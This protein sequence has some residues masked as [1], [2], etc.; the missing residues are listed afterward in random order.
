ML[1]SSI[2]LKLNNILIVPH[3]VKNLISISQPI[4]DNNAVVEF[5]D[6]HVFCQGQIEEFDHTAG[7]SWTRSL[8]VVIELSALLSYYSSL[9][10]FRR[11][12]CS[13]FNVFCYFC[14]H[15]ITT[16]CLHAA[17]DPCKNSICLSSFSVLRQNLWHPNSHVLH[18]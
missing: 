13:S 10:H 15:T 6:I 14:V 4:K 3:K 17:A 18:M 7:L 5:T 1:K 8:Q 9:C 12:Y 11:T 2:T 16:A